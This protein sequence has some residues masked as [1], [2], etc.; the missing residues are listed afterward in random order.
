MDCP[1]K[2]EVLEMNEKNDFFFSNPPPICQFFY[3]F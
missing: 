3:D 2:R 1:S